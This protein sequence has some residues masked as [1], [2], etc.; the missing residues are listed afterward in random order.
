MKYRLHASLVA[1]V[2]TLTREQMSADNIGHLDGGDCDG[3][4]SL[5]FDTPERDLYYRSGMVGRS[6]H[7]IHRYGDEPTLGSE[8]KR[9]QKMVVR[10][11]RTAVSECCLRAWLAD[12]DSGGSHLTSAET[13]RR[14]SAAMQMVYRI[15]PSPPSRPAELVAALSA[16]PVVEAVATRTL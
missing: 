5:Y 7:R 6:K 12:S 15:E 8:P 3:I 11:R 13:I 2:R 9:K 4:H 1:E 16:L 10:N 14:G